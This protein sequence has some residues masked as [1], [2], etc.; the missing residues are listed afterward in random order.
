MSNDRQAHTSRFYHLLDDLARHEEG[1][2][3]LRDCTGADGWPRHGV[4]FFYE[5]G[6]ARADGSPRV[7]RVG[8]HALTA[9]S[10]TTL[11]GR[12][13]QHRGRVGGRNPGGGNHRASI[14]RSHVGTALI[15]RG[16]WPD[17]LLDAWTGRHRLPVWAALEDQVE[18]EVSR[19]IGA[20]PFLWLAV[21]NRQDGDS[22]R[23]SIE[24][25]S[26]AL[27]SCLIGG[28][29][30]SSGSWLGRYAANSNVRQSGLWNS[31][32][33]HDA[34]DSSFLQVL[35]GHLTSML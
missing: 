33:V 21:P 10:T 35:E 4:Y 11:W 16:P 30:Q 32:H 34:Y 31:N 15:R 20:M 27:L 29:D 26:I 2:R 9:T 25:N 5:D 14:F 7:V 23:G 24:R 1:P 12:L 22:D 8:T 17:D 13:R 18:L 3:R 28:P 6:E 19:Y